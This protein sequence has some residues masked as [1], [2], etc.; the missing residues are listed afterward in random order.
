MQEYEFMVAPI[1]YN[2]DTATEDISRP[3]DYVGKDGWMLVSI[4]P[5]DYSE[6]KR[7]VICILQRQ[8]RA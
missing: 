5:D 7:C 1:Q 6:E 8:K 2:R 4:I 3:L